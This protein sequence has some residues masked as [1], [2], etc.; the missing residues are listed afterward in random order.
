[1]SLRSIRPVKNFWKCASSVRPIIRD[2]VALAVLTVGEA[3][4]RGAH[5][6]LANDTGPGPSQ[7]DARGFRA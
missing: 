1:M 6:C 5:V 4:R 7:Q 3:V 2:F